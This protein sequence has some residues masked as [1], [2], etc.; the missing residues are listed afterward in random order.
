MGDEPVFA[1]SSK[2]VGMKQSLVYYLGEAPGGMRT[3]WIMHEYRLSNG[4]DSGSSS[5]RS[6]K[7]KGQPK[8]VCTSSPTYYLYSLS[9]H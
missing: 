3:N 5:S 9:T 4:T 2:K 6:S 7:R 8:I 1:S